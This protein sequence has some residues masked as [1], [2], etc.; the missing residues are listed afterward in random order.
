[1]PVHC[2]YPTTGGESS[3]TPRLPAIGL[4]VF[5]GVIAL[6]MSW[7]VRSLFLEWSKN[8][9]VN[10]YVLWGYPAEIIVPGGD[11]LSTRFKW[12]IW[13][14]PWWSKVWLG[15]G[16]CLNARILVWGLENDQITWQKVSLLPTF[17]LRLNSLPWASCGANSYL[18]PFFFVPYLL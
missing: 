2:M 12:V 7:L 4:L 1:M 8:V 5:I 6:V 9:V 18:L 11:G 16:S 10:P 3:P 14:S 13:S 15:A 17:Y